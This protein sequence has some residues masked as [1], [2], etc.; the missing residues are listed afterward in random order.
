[1]Y[2]N[3]GNFAFMSHHFSQMVEILTQV[4]AVD[5]VITRFREEKVV[6]YVKYVNSV[7]HQKHRRAGFNCVLR[8]SM[9]VKI[10]LSGPLLLFGYLLVL[11]AITAGNEVPRVKL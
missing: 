8:I 4:G 2:Y 9:Y 1:M 10:V 6:A 11:G 5:D 7:Q 3:Y